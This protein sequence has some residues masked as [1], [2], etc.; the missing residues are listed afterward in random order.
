MQ[1]LIMIGAYLNVILYCILTHIGAWWKATVKFG[2]PFFLLFL[3]KYVC[4]AW[5][6]SV[7]GELRDIKNISWQDVYEVL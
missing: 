4:N 2:S 6:Q 7:S 1:K 5:W 3:D